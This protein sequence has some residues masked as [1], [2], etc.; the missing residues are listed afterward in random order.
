MSECKLKRTA[1][2]KCHGNV[3][4]CECCNVPHCAE[5]SGDDNPELCTVCWNKR[6]KHPFAEVLGLLTRNGSRFYYDEAYHD[7]TKKNPRLNANGCDTCSRPAEFMTCSA[8]PDD[9]AYYACKRC[10]R[11]YALPLDRAEAGATVKQEVR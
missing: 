8:E 4:R 6:R 11:T 9:S 3:Q 10:V 5:M 7:G 1:P 2:H